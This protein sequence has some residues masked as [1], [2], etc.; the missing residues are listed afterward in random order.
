M[1]ATPAGMP[2]AVTPTGIIAAVVT[3]ITMD[4]MPAGTRMER[5]M[6]VV[7]TLS[8]IIAAVVTIITIITMDAMPAGTR[9]ERGMLAAAASITPTGTHAAVA[10]TGTLTI[11]PGTRTIVQL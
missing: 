4:A 2:V 11:A 3:I 9:M 6:P 8:G 7:V 1:D 10:H 5:G